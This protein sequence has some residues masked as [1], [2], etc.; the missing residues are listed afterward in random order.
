M[1]YDVKIERTWV[2]HPIDKDG[3]KKIVF[4]AAYF[5]ELS[6]KLKKPSR[7]IKK[8]TTQA[9]NKALNDIIESIKKRYDRYENKSLSIEELSKE[10][11]QYLDSGERGLHYQTT[12]QYKAH[13]KQF[14]NEID[15]PSIL[16]NN[17]ERTYF[18]KYFDKM[19]PKKSYSFVNVRRSAIS[20]MYNFGLDYGYAKVNPLAGFKLKGSNRPQL[21]ILDNKYFTPK[22]LEAILSYYQSLGRY[23]YVDL[24]EWL[25]LTGMRIGEACALYPSDIYHT[26]GIYYAKIVGTQILIHHEEN[27]RIKGQKVNKNLQ[28]PVVHKQDTT[29]N[30]AGTRLVRLEPEAVKIY[31]RHKNSKTYLFTKQSSPAPGLSE[32]SYGQ[33]FRG[34][35]VTRNLSKIAKDKLGI[36]KKVTSHVFRH[37]YV[38]KCASYSIPFDEKFLSQIG[39]KNIMVI[40]SIYDHANSVNSQSLKEGFTKLDKELSKFQSKIE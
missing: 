3:N 29:K 8:E 31:Q 23:D 18:N 10:Y 21:E 26:N 22:E 35:S 33:P 32:K 25:Y 12:Y 5:D 37:T 16:A 1:S 24:L 7:T 4:R 19:L 11:I 27:R 15:D 34:Q 13:I 28:H 17:L 14:L 6:Q 2:E 38:S 40:R 30:W 36:T 9:K 20:S 39:H